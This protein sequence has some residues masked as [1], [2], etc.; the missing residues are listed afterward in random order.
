M[1]GERIGRR[2]PGSGVAA[3]LRAWWDARAPL[4]RDIAVILVIKACVL[5]L[6]WYAFF[7][8]PAA[9]RMTMDPQRVQDRLFSPSPPAPETSHAVR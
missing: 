5:G 1:N 8:T 7:R 6:L 4:A 2:R 3:N 9:P